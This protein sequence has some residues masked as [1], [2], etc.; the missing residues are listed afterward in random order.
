MFSFTSTVQ[1]VNQKF[2]FSLEN[3]NAQRVLHGLFSAV[4]KL[5]VM[6]FVAEE[7]G[8]VTAPPPL[9]AAARMVS[10]CGESVS[11]A[12]RQSLKDSVCY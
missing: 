3:M 9:Y 2:F 11:T 12:E 10:F 4:Q 8:N 6:A 7:R 5:V 1:T